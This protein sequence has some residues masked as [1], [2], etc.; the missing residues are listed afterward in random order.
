MV[1][2][3]N[4]RF[5]IFYLMPLLAI[6]TALLGACAVPVPVKVEGLAM[7]PAFNDGDRVLMTQ[8][9]G[10]IV[11]GDVIM[12]LYP[13]DQSR[14]YIK[15]VIGL[16]GDK[17]A[18]MDGRVYINGDPYEEAYIDPEY[19]HSKAKLA[20]ETVPADHYFVMGDNRDNSS[21]SRS[22]GTVRTELI[23]GKYYMKYISGKE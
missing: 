13:K 18:I 16:P 2:R 1:F 12:F 21:D 15:R 17:I 9:P 5:D 11:R 10:K 8:P 4:F 20:E 6:G 23:T 7:R 22:W 14:V 19:N 3:N